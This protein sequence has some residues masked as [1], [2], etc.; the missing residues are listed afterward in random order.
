VTESNPLDFFPT[1]E[2]WE[3][4]KRQVDAIEPTRIVLNFGQVMGGW[5]PPQQSQQ[6]NQLLNNTDYV[7]KMQEWYERKKQG[8]K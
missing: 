4:L 6:Y 3:S 8:G 5:Q 7:Q 2:E 1:F